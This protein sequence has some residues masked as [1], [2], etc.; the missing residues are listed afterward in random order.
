V[1]A[2]PINCGGCGIVCPPDAPLCRD[3]GCTACPDG[4]SNCDGRC[5]D[6]QRDRSN[7]SACGNQCA[8]AT[9]ICVNGACGPCPSPTSF[10][11]GF[12]RNL[13]ADAENCG[14]CDH[15]CAAPT[16]GCANGT[17]VTDC[18]QTLGAAYFP[19]TNCSGACVALFQD[20]QNCG[21]CGVQCAPDEL[22]TQ[23]VCSRCR[24]SGLTDC[25]SY[26]ADTSTD[27]QNCGG[28]G[29]VCP[30]GQFCRNHVCGTCPANQTPCN[31]GCY[32]HPEC[33]A[34]PDPVRATFCAHNGSF[35]GSLCVDVVT[36]PNNC[37]SCDRKCLASEQCQSG[38]CVPQS[39]VG[40]GELEPRVVRIRRGQPF[41]LALTWTVPEPA[42]WSDLAALELRFRD[43]RGVLT[44]VRWDE[45]TNSLRLLLSPTGRFGPTFPP[46][47]RRIVRTR[48]A[49]LLLSDTTIVASGPSGRSVTL[50]VTLR[51]KP[52]GRRATVLVDAISDNDA[53]GQ[54]IVQDLG[55]VELGGRRAR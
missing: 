2:D 10:C 49:R 39:N 47:T 22:C 5:L 27:E 44:A 38:Q 26:C 37:G 15:R 12:C 4:T 9:P 6:L 17:C 20:E 33:L 32:P 19:T 50:A 51:L 3:G 11:G 21:G 55:R 25:G 18:P 16:P 24:S 14:I 36:D 31:G 54:Q 42:I 29:V 40:V 8:G 41:R 13:Q 48:R 46:T 23:S 28:C 52:R 53:G 34:C 1:Q 35:D 7:C 43:G 30:A 45:A